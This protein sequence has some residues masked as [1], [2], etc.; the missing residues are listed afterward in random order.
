KN[1][2][3]YKHRDYNNTLDLTVSK[4][5]QIAPLDLYYRKTLR[6]FF[7]SES[8]IHAGVY[9]EA[10]NRLIRPLYLQNILMLPC[11]KRIDDIALILRHQNHRSDPDRESLD[12]SRSLICLADRH[13]CQHLGTL[14]L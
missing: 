4:V 11:H 8:W 2:P 7:P 10:L 9:F 14:Y 13:N 1:S 3:H 5:L 6:V 12:D